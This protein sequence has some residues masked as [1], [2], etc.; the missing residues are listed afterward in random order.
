MCNWG[1]TIGIK[2]IIPSNLSSSGKNK[3]KLCQI[4]TCIAPI[5]KALN[6]NDIKTISCCCG[7]GSKNGWILLEDGRELIIK[8][9]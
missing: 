1:E 9:K 2:L 7:H 3:Y 5:I 8:E 4:D 6:E